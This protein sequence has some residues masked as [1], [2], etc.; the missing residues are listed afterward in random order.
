MGDRKAALV[1]VDVQ[2]DFLPGGALAVPDGDAV[3]PVVNSLA[4]RFDTVI[5]TADRHPPD[6]VGFAAS[7]PGSKPFTSIEDNGIERTVWPVHCVRETRG[8]ALSDELD[9]DRFDAVVEKGT[10]TDRDAYSGFLDDRGEP[11]GLDEELRK[12]GIEHVF[13]TGLAT[14]VCVRA[15]VLD[16]LRLGYEVTVVED[17]C[18]GLDDVDVGRALDEMREA[19]ANIV[20]AA[21]VEIG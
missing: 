14:E 3:I 10:R 18:R 20:R 9:S 12:R 5:A 7:H 19:G 21:D 11:V 4:S 8:S 2:N 1:V 15:T 16:A 6:H 13:V 17:G